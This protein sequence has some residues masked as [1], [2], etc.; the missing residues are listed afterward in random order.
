MLLLNLLVDKGAFKMLKTTKNHLIGM[1]NEFR[2][3]SITEE[4]YKL[5]INEFTWV[6]YEDLENK[7]KKESDSLLKKLKKSD[8]PQI[9]IS[10]DEQV[11]GTDIK[12]RGLTLD[13]KVNKHY[14]L[15]RACFEI[16]NKDGVFSYEKYKDSHLIVCVMRDTSA[17]Y[18]FPASLIEKIVSHNIGD[19]HSLPDDFYSNKRYF[20]QKKS[21][22][23]RG[24]IKN[25]YC[26]EPKTL[27]KVLREY[28][29]YH[30]TNADMI[31][32]LSKCEPF[33]DKEYEYQS[34]D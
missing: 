5:P 31:Y 7:C 8:Q 15:D 34:C 1:N 13:V 20:E 12:F 27:N 26:I 33:I 18:N 21:K 17:I 23:V 6:I 29:A 11:A 28:L 4:L 25:V 14:P 10:S 32:L 30:C 3:L 2:I 9:D 24:K 16:F 22:Q 19:L